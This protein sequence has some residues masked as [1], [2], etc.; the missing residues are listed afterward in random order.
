MYKKNYHKNYTSR[1]WVFLDKK[2]TEKLEVNGK[3][4]KSFISINGQRKNPMI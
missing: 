3:K 2:R 1:I 4:F